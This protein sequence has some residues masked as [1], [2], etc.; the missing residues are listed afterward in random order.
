MNRCKDCKHLDENE[1]EIEI[2]DLESD[3]MLFHPSGFY[4]CNR[5]QHVSASMDI[6]EVQDLDAVVVDGSGYFAALRVRDD[7]GCMGFEAK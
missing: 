1:I 5:V 2:E 6:A 4:Q 7:F 3:D